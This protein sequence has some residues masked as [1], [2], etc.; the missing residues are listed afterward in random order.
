MTITMRF[1]N[2]YLH[3]IK[4]HEKVKITLMAHIDVW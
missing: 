2:Q 4:Q 3:L 1:I